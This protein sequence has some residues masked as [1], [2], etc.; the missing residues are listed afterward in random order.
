MWA[1]HGCG[2]GDCGECVMCLHTCVRLCAGRRGVN[3]PIE[4]QSAPWWSASVWDS[5]GDWP[6]S[7]VT[8]NKIVN[9]TDF[10][11]FIYWR[12]EVAAKLFK[13]LLM[14]TATKVVVGDFI[15]QVCCN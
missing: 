3:E 13:L 5:C 10:T 11:T 15:N 7:T 8:V 12:E 6:R 4:E 9:S 14:F 1:S 2:C